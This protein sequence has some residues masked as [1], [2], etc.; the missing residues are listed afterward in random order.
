MAESSQSGLLSQFTT[1]FGFKFQADVQES[2]SL[3]MRK[4]RLILSSTILEI[5]DHYTYPEIRTFTYH[6]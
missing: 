4:D 6:R 2:G 5:C 3:G 1:T